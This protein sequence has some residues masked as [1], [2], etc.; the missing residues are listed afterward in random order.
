MLI[1]VVQSLSHVWLF[2]TPRATDFPALHYISWS[3]LKL[4]TI[5]YSQCYG[6]SSNPV[7]MWQ[8]NH[9]EGWALKN[10]CFQIVVLERTL[11]SPLDSQ[12]IK[13]VNLKEIN[14]DYSLK[15]LMLKFLQLKLKNTLAVEWEE[16]T[17][18]KRPWC[19]ERLKAKEKEGSR[20]WDS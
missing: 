17:H 15:E 10:W 9:K 14:P 4:M 1:I 12:E 2:V 7:Q 13:T 18:W 11:E 8:L 3:L 5:E 6:F 20:G 19:R 16:R